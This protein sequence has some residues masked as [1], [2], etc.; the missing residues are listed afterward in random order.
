MAENMYFL[1]TLISR[2]SCM[3]GAPL[4]THHESLRMHTEQIFAK[5]ALNISENSAL[6]ICH[7]KILTYVRGECRQL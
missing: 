6:L 7:L 3:H 1:K 2:S 5:H 4:H